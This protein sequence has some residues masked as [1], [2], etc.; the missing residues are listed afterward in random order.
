MVVPGRCE[1]EA[2]SKPL[3][4]EF[5]SLC[6]SRCVTAVSTC[7]FAES[8]MLSTDVSVPGIMKAILI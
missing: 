5:G 1:P 4:P 7:L 2:V 6:C 3:Q 8:C